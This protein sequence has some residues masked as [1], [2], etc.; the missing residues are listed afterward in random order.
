M[1]VAPELEHKPWKESDQP[2]SS[3]MVRGRTKAQHSQ[4]IAKLPR[5]DLETRLN[6]IPKDIRSEGRAIACPL[7]K[8][9]HPK[10]NVSIPARKTALSRDA[11]SV[12]SKRWLYPMRAA[13]ALRRR[14]RRPLDG[15]MSESARHP[16]HRDTSAPLCWW[17][18]TEWSW[19][20]RVAVA[21]RS[22]QSF[23]SAASARALSVSQAPFH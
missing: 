16:D 1:L 19:P 2:E 10:V 21:S 9:F 22:W 8:R 14:L 23:R 13:F 20:G 18:A 4:E 5:T 3:A 7:L 15:R 11:S 12:L 17:T 6:N